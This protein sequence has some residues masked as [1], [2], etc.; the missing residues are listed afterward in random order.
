M[1]LDLTFIYIS[2]ESFNHTKNNIQLKKFKQRE[3]IM[4]L[5]SKTRVIDSRIVDSAPNSCSQRSCWSQ[6]T[7][8][9]SLAPFSLVNLLNFDHSMNVVENFHLRFDG[10]STSRLKSEIPLTAGWGKFEENYPQALI[11]QFLSILVLVLSAV[12]FT[13]INLKI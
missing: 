2:E 8:P 5:I 13:E 10:E 1:S 3:A 4:H 7:Y 12:I 6:A 9:L 11:S